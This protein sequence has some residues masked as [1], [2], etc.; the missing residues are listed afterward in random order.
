MYLKPKA[1]LLWYYFLSGNP[2]CFCRCRVS[3]GDCPLSES[4]M[5]RAPVDALFLTPVQ[6]RPS[7][8]LPIF[9]P[10]IEPQRP[11]PQCL[12][13]LY[14]I[15]SFSWALCFLPPLH[16]YTS[17]R[18]C[19]FQL[20]FPFFLFSFL[21]WHS[22]LYFWICY[23][24]PCILL[25]LRHVS[26]T[27]MST[28]SSLISRTVSRVILHDTWCHT[29]HMGG[30]VMGWFLGWRISSSAWLLSFSYSELKMIET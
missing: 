2:E 6:G 27:S 22:R 4:M 12:S 21:V 10:L 3:A 15:V 8:C 7:L 28:A 23:A 9:C 20:T 11:S 24:L 30:H 5:T 16:V 1:P 13:E 26:F 19:L 14:L 18:F 29:G 25:H 17:F